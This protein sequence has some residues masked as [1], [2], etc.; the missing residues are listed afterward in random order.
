MEQE[1][2]RWWGLAGTW[3]N[4]NANGHNNSGYRWRA[5]AVAL[6]QRTAEKA[7]LWWSGLETLKGRTEEEGYI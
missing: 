7:V 5:P 1:F 6:G 4:S 3:I 2:R